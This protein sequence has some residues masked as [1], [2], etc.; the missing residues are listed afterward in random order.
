MGRKN[1]LKDKKYPRKMIIH[2]KPISKKEWD[3]FIPIF[4]DFVMTFEHNFD[5]YDPE[6]E[7][8]SDK[9]DIYLHGMVKGMWGMLSVIEERMVEK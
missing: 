4:T 7:T 3:W 1:K 9:F 2:P 5:I 6:D 8:T